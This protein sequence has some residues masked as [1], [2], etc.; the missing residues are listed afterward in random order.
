MN[1]P[2]PSTPPRKR[3]II[4]GT[5]VEAPDEPEA[6]IPVERPAEYVEEPAEHEDAVEPMHTE[7]IEETLQETAASEEYVEQVVESDVDE[8]Q[9]EAPIESEEGDFLMMDSQES[10]EQ[11][12]EQADEANAPPETAKFEPKTVRRLLPRGAVHDETAPVPRRF[13]SFQTSSVSVGTDQLPLADSESYQDVAQ[14]EYT[15]Q[16]HAAANVAAPMASSP[17]AAAA[18]TAQPQRPVYVPAKSGVPIWIFSLIGFLFGVL[19]VL[20]FV[21]LGLMPAAMG[22]TDQKSLREAVKDERARIIEV[23]ENDGHDGED[24]DNFVEE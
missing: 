20:T 21:K 3:L 8:T 22:L 13:S 14:Q 7:T 9:A 23:L 2:S 19:T 4:P 1:I 18:P 17:V 5:P 16:A 6:P 15:E 10:E 12:I 24:W 11:V